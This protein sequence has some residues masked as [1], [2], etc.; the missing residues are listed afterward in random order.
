MG[1]NGQRPPEDTSP[2]SAPPEVS[3]QLGG[4]IALSVHLCAIVLV[5]AALYFGR[6]LLLP[7][8][9]AILISL[10]LIPIVRW[11]DRQGIRPP[12]SAFALVTSLALAVGV[13]GYALSGPV[14]QWVARAPS[15]G[16]QIEMKLAVFRGSVQAVAEAGKRVE[17][18]SS[19][20]ADPDV[21]QVVVREPGLLSSATSTLWRGLSTAG[22][23]LLLVLFLLASGDMVYEKIVRILPTLTDKKTA[24]R[25]IHDI[26][27][28][29]SRYLLTISL[30]NI[31]LG[32]AV[33]CAMWAIGMPSPALWGAAATILNFLPYLGAIIGVVVTAIAALISL[34]PLGYASLA[35]LAYLV[36]TVLEGSIITPLLLGRRLELNTIAILVGVAFWGWLWGLVGILIAVPLLVVVKTICDHLPTWSTLGEFL[37]VTVPKSE[38]EREQDEPDLR[39]AAKL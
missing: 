17:E 22:V 21:Q 31:G 10:T 4:S 34:D 26:E 9:L 25:I 24:L 37:S 23:T 36:L 18:L 6:D 39:P 11:L 7:I 14:S 2:G 30:I 8:T 16:Q 32:V 38:A 1:G 29:I 28:S 27:T 15:I 13:G 33:G 35:P 19:T 5:C 20:A 3:A 12:L